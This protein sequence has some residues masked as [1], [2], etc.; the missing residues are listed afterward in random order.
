MN[1]WLHIAC[2]RILRRNAVFR[3]WYEQ[4]LNELLYEL[5]RASLDGDTTRSRYLDRLAKVRRG[6]WSSSAPMPPFPWP[7]RKAA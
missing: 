3:H 6:D 2:W 4:H 7:W 1:V 5:E